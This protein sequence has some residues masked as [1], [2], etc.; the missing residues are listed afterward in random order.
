MFDLSGKATARLDD[1]KRLVVPRKFRETIGREALAGGLKVTVAPDGCLFVFPMPRWRE[2]VAE[3]AP[4][5]FFSKKG[6]KLKRA[7]MT[8]AETVS[9]DG[10]GRILLS[11]DLL[12]A[13]GL[14]DEVVF[15]GVN[16]HLEIWA[17]DRWER[18]EKEIE[19]DYEALAEE[20][21]E[22]MEARALRS[23]TITS[24]N[25]EARGEAGSSG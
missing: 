3:L 20:F 5:H 12:K 18:E 10:T 11:D 17:P 14:R 23:A 7:F 6:R 13:A 8:R 19:D 24:A 16:D 4:A 2:I 15:L 25:P 22:Q 21:Y 1:K 9:V